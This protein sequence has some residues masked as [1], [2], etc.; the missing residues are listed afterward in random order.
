[1]K[2]AVVYAGVGFSVVIGFVWGLLNGLDEEPPPE[3]VTGDWP[4]ERW[5]W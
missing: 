5:I 4:W 2:R 3:R 1:M